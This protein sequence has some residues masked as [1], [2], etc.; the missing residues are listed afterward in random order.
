MSD[1]PYRT[2]QTKY[3]RFR[4]PFARLFGYTLTTIAGRLRVSSGDGFILQ[5]NGEPL[6]K[7]T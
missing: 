7:S 5:S 6:Y 4:R 1:R 2:V 3:K